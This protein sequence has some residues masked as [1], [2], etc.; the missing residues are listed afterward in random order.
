M[1][2]FP[3]VVVVKLDFEAVALAAK[4]PDRGKGRIS[5]RA[6]GNIFIRFAIDDHCAGLIFLVLAAFNER[7]PVV[8]HDIDRV[9][10]RRVK[11]P[12]LIT[13]SRRACLQAEGL[14]VHE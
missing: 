9:Y 11:K 14:A 13:E 10:P 2:G 7:V 6:G 3:A 4:L 12:R 8:H 5:L 1:I